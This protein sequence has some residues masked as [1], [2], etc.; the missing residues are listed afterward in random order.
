MNEVYRYSGYSRQAFLQWRKRRLGQQEREALLLPIVEELR[1]EHPGVAA[2]QLYR[3]LKPQGIGRDKFEALCFGHGLKLMR[4][5]DF[6]RTTDSR[7]V[8]RFPNLAEGLEVGSVNQVWGSDITY[9]QIGAVFYFLTFILDRYS[10][11]V[12][13]YS[14]SRRLLTEQ[15]TLP[16]LRM[17]LKARR[18]CKGLIF[19]S[20]GGGQYYSGAFLKLTGQYHIK[21]SMCEMA[22]EN[23]HAERVNATIKNQYLKGYCPQTYHELVRQTKR[24]VHNY[25]CIRPH[26]SLNY[27][28]P[29]AYEKRRP[30]GGASLT[31]DDFCSLSTTAEQQKK[32]HQVPMR[33]NPTFTKPTKNS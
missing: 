25:N 15:T 20:D 18:P 23:P 7:G 24:A 5:K 32:N 29:E 27:I 2:R 6:R 8:I 16:A 22:Y 11:M 17:A 1:G 33:S 4:S 12:V 31:H 19:H 28:T 9:Y 21:N 3:I 13:G 14:V 10:R 26:Q 30:A